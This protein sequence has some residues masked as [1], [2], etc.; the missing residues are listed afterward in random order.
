MIPLN[1]TQKQRDTYVGNIVAAYEV[2]TLAQ[3]ARGAS[4]YH[5]AW[6]LCQF[7]DETNPRRAAGVLAALSANKRWSVNQDLALKAFAGDVEGHTSDTLAKVRRIL[8]GE[9]PEQ[10]LPVGRKTW[11]F[12]INISEPD[13][14]YAVTVDRHAH[15]IA[16]GESY[17]DRNRGLNSHARY[18]VIANAYIAAS[19]QLGKLPSTIQATTW[20]ARTEG[21]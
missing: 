5:N 14:H 1:P 12:F 7:L 10:V 8:A 13:N 11:W 3:R 9:N 20:V 18:R 15:D 19:V 4:W 2:A 16:V 6:S 17:G 21:K